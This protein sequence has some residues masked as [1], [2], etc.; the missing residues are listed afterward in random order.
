M[1]RPKFQRKL[2]SE[3]HALSFEA[4][5]TFM[6]F[7]SL[8]SIRPDLLAS[9]HL[10]VGLLEASSTILACSTDLFIDFESSTGFPLS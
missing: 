1:K 6:A 3:F 7:Q 10:F 5:V 2:L 9:F 8:V 4:K